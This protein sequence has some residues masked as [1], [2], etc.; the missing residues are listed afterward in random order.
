MPMRFLLSIVIVVFL[1]VPGCSPDPSPPNEDDGLRTCETVEDCRAGE[2]C[3]VG[4]CI[5]RAGGGPGDV[6][7]PDVGTDAGDPDPTDVAVPDGGGGTDED[8][9]EVP[10]S[11]DNCP[12][13]P[14]PE[15]LDG[16]GDGIGDACDNCTGVANHVQA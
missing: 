6:D 11:I 13:E 4:R 12:T 7:V 14:N 3:V 15:Q 1:A 5:L 10:D 16:D 9:D 2:A 8:G